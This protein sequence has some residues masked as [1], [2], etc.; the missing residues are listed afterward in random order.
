MVGVVTVA[1]AT[2]P[3][4]I[5]MEGSFFEWSV[6]TWLFWIGYSLVIGVYAGLRYLKDPL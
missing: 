2:A 1:L 4:M 6:L 3:G 5:A